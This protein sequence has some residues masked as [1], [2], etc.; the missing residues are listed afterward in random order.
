MQERTPATA[1]PSRNLNSSP[2]P[3]KLDSLERQEEEEEADLY[4]NC[5]AWG[6]TATSNL[7]SRLQ[8]VITG[9]GGGEACKT[10]T[11]PATVNGAKARTISPKLA[12]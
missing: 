4:A 5:A 1:P 2:T 9:E 6:E 8:T 11:R 10:D 12:Q 7:E 3:P